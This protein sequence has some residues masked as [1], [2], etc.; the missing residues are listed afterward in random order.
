MERDEFTVADWPALRDDEVREVLRRM[1][2]TSAT[3]DPSQVWVQW[4]SPRPMSA[5]ALVRRGDSELFV[6]RHHIAV[7]GPE[8]LRVE[9]RFAEHL[10]RRGQR[11][12]RVLCDPEGD[13]VV[14]EGDF[15]YEVHEKAAGI[16]LYRE[17]PSWYPYFTR[18]HA[19]DA[20]RVLARLHEAARD[21]CEPA[22]APGV[23]TD[24]SDV[25]S[26]RDPARALDR[27]VSSRPA[28]RRALAS[29]DFYGDVATHLAQPL[30]RA[31]ASLERIATQWGHGD[32]HPSNL[33][34]TSTGARAQVAGVFDLALANRTSAVHD[35]AIAL[36]RSVVDWLDLDH[37]GVVNADLRMLDAL[38]DGYESVRPLE[39]TER[40]ALV[41]V[42]PV[43]HVEFALSEVEYFAEVVNSKRNTDLAYDG[44]LI[45]HARWF[46]D[47]PGERLLA[48]LRRRV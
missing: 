2:P 20:G 14:R 29:R 5:A 44:Y 40:A 9:H 13:T 16:D 18:S 48:H 47:E 39:E 8:R 32:W 38:L 22:S 19:R 46:T 30:T 12:A 21:F 34:W 31:A 17:Q 3:T 24:S 41:D 28:L 45:G 4:R 37:D 26:A 35:L 33:T 27:L 1:G 15:V 6:K 36:E 43:V 23:L 10:R 7:R 11:V 25:A 42:L